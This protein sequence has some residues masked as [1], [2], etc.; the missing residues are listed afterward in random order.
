[1][2][3]ISLI[4]IVMFCTGV[5]IWIGA[6][7][8][9]IKSRKIS[10]RLRVE[11]T[12]RRFAEARK[13]LLDSVVKGELDPHSATFRRLYYLNTVVMR[14]PDQYDEISRVMKTFIAGGK[15]G[16]MPKS[17]KAESKNWTPGVKMAIVATSDA[18]KQLVLNYSWVLRYLLRLQQSFSLPMTPIL[19]RI[20]KLLGWLAKRIER[21]EERKHPVI[22]DIREVQN[23]MYNLA[24]KC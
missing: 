19:F 16:E 1:M 23:A 17:I 7:W 21:V 8:L 3:T 24:S 2:S 6:F 22:S 10:R 13:S 5:V 12:Q 4:I 14:R 9:Q 20:A 18:M 15:K 11:V